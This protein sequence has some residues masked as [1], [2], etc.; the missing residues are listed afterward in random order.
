[1]TADPDGLPRE[2]QARAFAPQP[3][4]QL[5]VTGALQRKLAGFAPPRNPKR[6]GSHDFFPQQDKVN[7]RADPSVGLAWALTPHQCW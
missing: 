2:A 3:P 7:H 5:S 1:M 6:T 4:A